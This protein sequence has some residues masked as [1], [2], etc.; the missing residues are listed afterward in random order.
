M[1]LA[2][3]LD[4]FGQEVNYKN[5]PFGATLMQM[6]IRFH[7]VGNGLVEIYYLKGRIMVLFQTAT[8]FSDC[9]PLHVKKTVVPNNSSNTISEVQYLYCKTVL[10]ESED[11]IKMEMQ[12]P[13]SSRVKF[14]ATCSYSRLN[15]FIKSRKN[16]PKLPQTLIS[17]SSSTD[18]RERFAERFSLRRKCS[19]D[20]T[21]VLKIILRANETLPD[22]K[23]HLTEEMSY[24]QG[25]PK[26]MQI[27]AF[28]GNAKCPELAIRFA[29][30][31]PQTVTEM[32]K[33]VDDF[34]KLEE[35]YK[36][37][38]LP[39]GEHPEKGQGTSYR[40]NRPPRAGHGG[41]HQR[42]EVK[43]LSLE[44]LIKRPKEILA[45][46]LQLQLPSC[47]L[48]PMVRTPKKKNLDKYCDYH[49][50]KR[51]Y[52]NDCY[53]LKRQ[54]EAALE[55]GKLSHLV[56]DVKRQ[57]NNRGRQQGTTTLIGR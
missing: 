20:P 46:E 9:N 57:G 40:V 51:H 43:Q 31:V 44:S 5:I 39:K 32:M 10:I 37:T 47:P 24:I 28:M 27:S 26:V 3:I 34:T 29:D 36:S 35:A 23:E 7:S 18:L 33:R 42:Q 55:S 1:L 49:V 17:T 6:T 11:Y 16:D 53:W 19:K 12:I 38:E 50:E 52:T 22:F 25:V 56:K 13:H 30:Q 15:D 41:G 45:T 48:S 54:L 21:E 14:I 4:Q 8:L 2:I